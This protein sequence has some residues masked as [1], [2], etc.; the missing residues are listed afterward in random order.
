[1]SRDMNVLLLR[2]RDDLK[3][4]K[5]LVRSGNY[6]DWGGFWSAGSEVSAFSHS[7]SSIV[8]ISVRD[9]PGDSRTDS[10]SFL[11]LLSYKDRSPYCTPA[12]SNPLGSKPFWNGSWALVHPESVVLTR[13][14]SL[15]LTS[16]CSLLS[17]KGRNSMQHELWC[18]HLLDHFRTA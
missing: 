9:D 1:M 7:P 16:V 18:V 17:N 14:S 13:W 10:Q 6:R 3:V 15:P 12:H 11:K 4:A 8:H 5:E 2:W